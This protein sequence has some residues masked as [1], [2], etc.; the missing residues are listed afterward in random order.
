MSYTGLYSLEDK[1]RVL[2][3]IDDDI[4]QSDDMGVLLFYN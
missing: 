4:E 1:K 2:K 3:M